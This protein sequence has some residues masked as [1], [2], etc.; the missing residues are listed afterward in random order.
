[1]GVGGRTHAHVTHMHTRAQKPARPHM[2]Q[3]THPLKDA[4]WARVSYHVGH[5][6]LRGHRVCGFQC[7]AMGAAHPRLHACIERGRA[8][9]CA[10]TLGACMHT[11]P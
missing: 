4:G 11:H 3:H 6:L 1:M 9:M 7:L 10:R 2:R 5:R 8:C